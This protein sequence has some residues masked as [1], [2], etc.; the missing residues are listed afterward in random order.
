M[1]PKQHSDTY[2]K[3]LRARPNLRQIGANAMQDGAMLGCRSGQES[4]E[5]MGKFLRGSRNFIEQK[6]IKSGSEGLT[7]DHNRFRD[8]VKL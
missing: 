5:A 3:M 2:K 1:K 8:A 6:S 4:T 7:I